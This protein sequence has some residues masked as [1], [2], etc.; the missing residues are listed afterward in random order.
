MDMLDDDPASMEPTD[1]AMAKPESE[2][3][4]SD[5]KERERDC[6]LVKKILSRIKADKA[7]H[8]KAFDRMRRDMFIAMNGRK[9]SWHADNYTANIS[10]RHVKQ[11]T[12]SLYAKNP[13]AVARRRE[14]MDFTVWDESPDSL[15][16]AMQTVQAAQ[17]A[18]AMAGPMIDP[19]T[20]TPA[21]DPLTGQPI[22]AEPQLPPGFEQAQAVVADFQQG[23]QR[24]EMTKK[25]GK[26]LEILFTY[27]MRE[28]K[29]IDFKTAMKQTVRR[30]GTTCVGYV[31][32]GFQRE[33]GP[34]PGVSEQLA[35]ARA[36]LDHLRRLTEEAG[37]GEIDDNEAEAAEL[38]MSMEAL[39]AEP[40]IV[41]R[42]GLIFDFPPSTKVIPDLMCRSLT[43]FVGARHISIEYLFTLDQAKEMFPE[44]KLDDAYTGYHAN[45]KVLGESSDAKVFDTPDDGNGEEGTLE[46]S[47]KG[48]LV[49]VYKHY[50]KVSG[51]C[52]YVADGHKYFLRKPAPPDVFVEDF[53]PVYALTFNAV[54]SETELFPP[55]DVGLMLPMQEEYNRSRQGMRE[56]RDAARPRWGY[57]KGR[58]SQ[59]DAA[60]LASAKP[61]DVIALEIDGQTK[62]A[63]ILEP[64]PVPGVDPNLYGT[65]QY[66]TDIQFTVGS[67]E[68]QMGGISRATATESSIAASASKTSD[69]ASV[70]DLDA[71]LTVIARASG[72]VLLKEMSEEK[73]KEIAG[74]GAVWPQMS[75]ADISKEIYLEV[76]AGS[77]GKPN[78]AVEI[79]NWQ[80]MAPFIMQ[81]PGINPTWLA[82]ET[83][84]R[85]DDKAD[86]VEAIAAGMPS[87]VMQ[88]QNTQ[89]AAGDATAD[90]TAQGPQGAQNGPA[91]P[92][93]EMRG[94]EPAFGS[95]QVP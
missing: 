88:N 63:D 28:Q 27:F 60:K 57:A 12:A 74:P 49:C 73:V 45:G 69:D 18:L 72:Q 39:Q 22:M 47:D 20:G 56:H 34:R 31:E 9:E 59:E 13:K 53:W 91:P 15:M 92:P 77:S 40:E 30:T 51:L 94:S 86:M 71:F 24:R 67:S 54:E 11:K 66:F 80:K 64:I 50:D 14:T 19:A 2:D 17:Q 43:G 10:G 70:D 36:R 3:G 8:K 29:P 25:L 33:Y 61:F 55:S 93:E 87:I 48:G 89:P 82:K 58:L 65:D 46:K 42:E 95:N 38:I 62:L 90:P 68:A 35:D 4:Y 1:G 85:L 32:L 5:P 6:A 76:E 75:L 84:R 41:M 7:H 81:T 37:E 78:Q 16:L 44:A 21:L 23:F 26:T 79:D 52:Y 83:I